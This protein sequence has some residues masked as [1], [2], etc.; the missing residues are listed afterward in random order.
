MI[1]RLISCLCLAHT[2]AQQL[3]HLPR[4]MALGLLDEQTKATNKTQLVQTNELVLAQRLS[5]K[6]FRKQQHAQKK[7]NQTPRTG[8][9]AASDTLNFEPPTVVTDTSKL[10]G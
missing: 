1:A 9:S 4:I 8:A 3:I 6:S 2:T 7:R 10:K 5:H